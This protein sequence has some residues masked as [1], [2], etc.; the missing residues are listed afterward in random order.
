MKTKGA[1][2]FY[3]EKSLIKVQY[4]MKPLG[5]LFI[6]SLRNILYEEFNGQ[7]IEIN[8]EK[9]YMQGVIEKT[10]EETQYRKSLHGLI[11]VKGV[12]VDDTVSDLKNEFDLLPNDQTNWIFPTKFLEKDRI[13]NIP[14]LFRKL[15]KEDF[16]GREQSKHVFESLVFKKAKEIGAEI[17][18]LDGYMA[19][20]DYLQSSLGMYGK[21]LNIHPAPTIIDRP[22]CFRGKDE[23]MDAIRFAKNNG[24]AALTGS[25]LHFV[26]SDLDSGHPVAYIC[27]TPVSEDDTELELMYRN[28]QEAK[29][30]IFIAGLKHYVLKIFP[31]LE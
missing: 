18:I 4:P 5:V 23:V 25:T 10:L 6:T 8:G 16:K 11:E 31:Y 13:W 14:S 9:F 24:G 15:P 1:L 2:F 26:D 19:R 22:F 20:L 28:Y 12:I 7:F 17:I 21:V 3:D 29:L 30:P 27:S